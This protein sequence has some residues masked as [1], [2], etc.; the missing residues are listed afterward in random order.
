[1]TYSSIAPVRAQRDPLPFV[2][3]G[4]SVRA[5]FDQLGQGQTL[6]FA[7][8][9]EFMPSGD[10]PFNVFLDDARAVYDDTDPWGWSRT[11]LVIIARQLQKLTG[12]I[13]E[14][15]STDVTQEPTN[16]NAVD[17]VEYFAEELG[18]QEAVLQLT[19]AGNVLNR[20]AGCALAAGKNY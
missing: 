15:W 2:V 5:G 9:A 12:S 17:E 14:H 11:W 1:M 7:P 6:L 16:T 18:E 10:R 3:N 20:L 4:T 8:R 19:H 13:P